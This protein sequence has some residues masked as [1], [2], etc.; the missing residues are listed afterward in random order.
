MGAAML[1]NQIVAGE[2]TNSTRR[3]QKDFKELRDAT[4]PLVGV[5]AAPTESN[6]FVWRANLRGPETSA[7]YGGVFHLEITFPQNYPVSPPDIRLKTTI[8]HPNVFGDKICLDMLEPKK[9]DSGWYDGWSSAY[10]VESILIQ[11]QS[12]LFEVPRKLRE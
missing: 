9:K 1:R 5:A 3:L 4:V 11:L 6:F 12:F 10:T 7:F 8:P 2:Q